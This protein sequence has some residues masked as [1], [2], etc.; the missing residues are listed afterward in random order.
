MI[1]KIKQL[2]FV[3]LLICIPCYSATNYSWTERYVENTLYTGTKPTGT[4]TGGGNDYICLEAGSE[5][6]D[7]LYNN[8]GVYITS[9][10]GAGQN[11]RIIDYDATGGACECYAQVDSAWGT[12][13]DNTSVYEI[14]TG[15]NSNDGT[16]AG[17]YGGANGAWR[18]IQ[19]AADTVSTGTRINVKSGREYDQIANIDIDTTNGTKNDPIMIQGYTSTV[20]DGGDFILDGQSTYAYNF[21]VAMD[22]WIFCD[23]EMKGSTTA[24]FYQTGAGADNNILIRCKITGDSGAVDGNWGDLRIIYNEITAPIEDFSK[25]CYGN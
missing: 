22:Y 13:P 19:H 4:A 16:A 2:L 17:V 11:K 8:Y 25:G 3:S 10:T 9:G 1:K 12:N 20:G 5:G 23:I 14:T 15:S 21:S 18:T 24:A 7:D 6:T